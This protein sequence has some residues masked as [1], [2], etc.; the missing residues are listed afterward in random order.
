VTGPAPYSITIFPL[1]AGLIL[2]LELR[3]I[4]E[5]PAVTLARIFMASPFAPCVPTLIC[6]GKITELPYKDAG[7]IK[8]NNI[9]NTIFILKLSQNIER[10][11]LA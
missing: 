7:N 9:L 3:A 4:R 8:I 10:A 5:E 11:N 1:S 6:S 2:I